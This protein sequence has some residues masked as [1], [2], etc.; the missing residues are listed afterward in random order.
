MQY[1]RRNKPANKQITEMTASFFSFELNAL[2]RRC[3]TG[4]RRVRR[5]RGCPDASIGGEA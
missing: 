3:A 5:A 4:A 1:V 2:R